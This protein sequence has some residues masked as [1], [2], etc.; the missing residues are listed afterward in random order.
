MSI[1]GMCRTNVTYNGKRNTVIFVNRKS[2][3]SETVADRKLFTEMTVNR[4]P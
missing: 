3:F 4:N 2:K 1:S